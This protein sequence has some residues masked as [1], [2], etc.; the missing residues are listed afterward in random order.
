MKTILVASA[1][2]VAF[3]SPA[4][5]QKRRPAK[6]NPGA[7]PAPAAPAPG[8]VDEPTDPAGEAAPAAPGTGAG[9]YRTG[10]GMAGCGLGSILFK[11]PGKGAQIG[12]WF[13]NGTFYS[14]SSGITSGT[15]NC[16]TKGGT[17]FVDEQT[18]FVTAN[19]DKLSQEA[20][21]GS[22]EHL[23]SFAEVL[24]CEGDEAN[25]FARLSQERYSFLFE[26][27]DARNVIARAHSVIRESK[28]S[29]RRV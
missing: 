23:A 17:A 14:Q 22:G 1:L 19:L 20:A 29:C 12:A 24:G 16:K 5:A 4:F 18:T 8:P 7:R 25:A 26:S 15:S 27:N 11:S 10:Y 21:Q 28:L 9:T 2:A 6:P 3:A 13:F